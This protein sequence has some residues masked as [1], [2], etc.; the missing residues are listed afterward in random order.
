[1]TRHPFTE[2]PAD[3]CRAAL[4]AALELFEGEAFLVDTSSVALLE[5]NAAG[6]AALELSRVAALK[7]I[8]SALAG[9]LPFSAFLARIGGLGGDHYALLMLRVEGANVPHPKAP[10]S[11][12]RRQRQVLEGIARGATNQEISQTLGIAPKTIEKHVSALLRRAGC[13]SR[14]GLITTLH[15]QSRSMG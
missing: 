7:R 4:R 12:T 9:E 6:R 13:R 11:L 3:V 1:V 2:L 8:R 14:A 15:Q 10:W 5:A